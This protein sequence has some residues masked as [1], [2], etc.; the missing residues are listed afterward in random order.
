MAEIY[1]SAPGILAWL[2]P[3]AKD[4]HAAAAHKEFRMAVAFIGDVATQNGVDFETFH[5]A[6]VRKWSTIWSEVVSGMKR[7]FSHPWWK[8]L[9]VYQEIILCKEAMIL[10]G[11]DSIP[12]ETVAL[13]SDVLFQVTKG[14]AQW[15]QRGRV[16]D[17]M[18]WKSLRS[19]D[20]IVAKVRAGERRQ[21]HH[22]HDSELRARTLLTDQQDIEAIDAMVRA[23]AAE[24]LLVRLNF[25]RDLKCSDPRDR[26]FALLGTASP[27]AKMIVPD[28]TKSYHEVYWDCA[29]AMAYST[30]EFLRS[31]GMGASGTSA[32]SGPQI[33]VPSWVPDWHRIHSDPTYPGDFPGIYNASH[34]DQ[35][36]GIT[37]ILD[38][39]RVL[40][41]P[42]YLVDSVDK[43]LPTPFKDDDDQMTILKAFPACGDTKEARTRFRKERIR[44]LLRTWTA[45]T[46][47]MGYTLSEETVT[48][49]IKGN[50]LMRYAYSGLGSNIENE[51]DDSGDDDDYESS[52][53][54][55]LFEDSLDDDIEE[56]VA[57]FLEG[58][59][60]FKQAKANH[61]GRRL[62]R[63]QHGRMALG[64][65]GVT[66]GDVICI[67][68][69]CSMPLVLRKD[70]AKKEFRLIGACYVHGIMDGEAISCRANPTSFSIR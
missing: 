61:E 58:L 2:G 54:S 35:K 43:V 47:V 10:L 7:I 53:E 13:A 3:S 46:D 32:T 23:M 4:E 14:P 42:G 25:T 29:K 31:A 65:P 50:F 38:G 49:W 18:L 1:H 44:N 67:V 12:L 28:Y 59:A 45:N 66:A 34:E 62:L 33:I 9:W 16:N 52:S 64:P 26:V 60:G 5:R 15:V 30:L 41:V 57:G 21:A 56:G 37:E 17:W 51:E 19:V 68:F 11:Q 24:Q 39:G 8:R 27:S 22:A 36:T 70:L 48:T 40:S 55:G 6:I 69:Q 63:T 20:F